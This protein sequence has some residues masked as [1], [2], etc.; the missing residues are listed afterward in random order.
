MK[1][2]TANGHHAEEVDLHLGP[3]GSVV[4]ACVEM[5]L[6]PE[7]RR[8]LFPAVCH[9]REGGATIKKAV[10]RRTVIVAYCGR[11]ER[12]RPLRGRC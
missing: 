9:W 8:V 11:D 6:A 10:E 12:H 7:M 4:F 5:G 3:N 1:T 2:A